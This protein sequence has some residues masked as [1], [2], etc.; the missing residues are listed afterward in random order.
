[1]SPET[2]WLFEDRLFKCVS[3][4]S[5]DPLTVIVVLVEVGGC[6]EEAAVG[7]SG[8]RWK[9]GVPMGARGWARGK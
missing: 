1:M 9:Q 5:I 3:H 4:R 6:V 8:V 7:N 2:A